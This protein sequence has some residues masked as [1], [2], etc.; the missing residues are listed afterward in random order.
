MFR[1][2]GLFATHGD[3]RGG[4]GEWRRGFSRAPGSVGRVEGGG[5]RGAQ[6]RA[7]FPPSG[8]PLR[9]AA[10]DAPDRLDSPL[11]CHTRPP[12]LARFLV[13]WL[14]GERFSGTALT[15][16]IPSLRSGTGVSS[17]AV[18]VDRVPRPGTSRCPWR[19]AGRDGGG[20][21]RLQP[22]PQPRW[23]GGGRWGSWRVAAGPI[24]PLRGPLRSGSGLWSGPGG[25]REDLCAPRGGGGM[26][27]GG[28][29]LA[30]P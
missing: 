23:P 16:C 18:E 6:R 22:R 11:P 1:V 5:A 2:L 30:E 29:G 27:G 28:D 13:C 12:G 26:P 9:S 20:E 21:A 25:A 4:L 10:G 19:S 7:P 14:L 17:S 8:H 24:P 3:R 15:R